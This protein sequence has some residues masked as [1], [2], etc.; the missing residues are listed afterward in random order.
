MARKQTKP[1]KSKQAPEDE[2][3]QVDVY[4]IPAPFAEMYRV[5]REAVAHDAM[6]YLKETYD[7]V[8]R[9]S[10]NEEEGEAI[11]A[12]DD[13]GNE[14]VRFYLN[15]SNVS[16]AQKARDKNQFDKMME[17]FVSMT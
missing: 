3:V 8:I 16:E 4:M 13:H 2:L 5:L 7:E 15:P 10:D 14:C 6:L 1:T 9:I 12:K 11:V 17:T